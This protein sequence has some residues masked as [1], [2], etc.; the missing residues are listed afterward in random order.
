VTPVGDLSWVSRAAVSRTWGALSCSTRGA[1][2]VRRDDVRSKRA[3]ARHWSRRAPDVSRRFRHASGSAGP[4]STPLR[5]PDR[6]HL[7]SDTRG[8]PQDGARTRHVARLHHRGAHR[9][10]ARL[11]GEAYK[12]TK[13]SKLDTSS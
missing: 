11:A 3:R 6:R 9:E 2:L 13:P 12:E 10:R 5:A 1:Y 8:T 7:V 4:G